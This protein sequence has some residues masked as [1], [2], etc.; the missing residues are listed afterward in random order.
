L[1]PNNDYGLEKHRNG[2]GNQANSGVAGTR[3]SEE[4]FF[5]SR[6]RAKFASTS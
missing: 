3:G 1:V 4:A 6:M 5:R 2:L